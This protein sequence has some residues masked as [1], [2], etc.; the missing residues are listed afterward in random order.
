MT[1][2]KYQLAHE[3]ADDNMEYFYKTLDVQSYQND[4]MKLIDAFLAGHKAGQP[5]WISVEDALPELH[6]E[7]RGTWFSEEVLVTYDNKME[8]SQYYVF[9]TKDNEKKGYWLLEEPFYEGL[10]T[11]WMPLP[12][13]PTKEGSE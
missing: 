9:L 8:V 5:K 4:N 2:T 11:H 12:T 7:G 6:D 1:K 13:L 10:V 3:Y